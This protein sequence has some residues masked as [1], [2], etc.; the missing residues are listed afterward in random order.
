MAGRYLEML[1]NQE[2]EG[3]LTSVFF[4]LRNSE[5]HWIHPRNELNAMLFHNGPATWLFILTLSPS[6]W[7]WHEMGDY[8]HKLIPNLKSLSISALVA[9]DPISTSHF[10]D[11]KLKAFLEFI[12]S[13]CKP[14]GEVTHYCYRR[15]YQG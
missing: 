13:D 2:I 6:E 3:N 10:I 15:E 11:N 4:H 9:V 12:T 5:Q 7:S 1:E 14:I 8:L